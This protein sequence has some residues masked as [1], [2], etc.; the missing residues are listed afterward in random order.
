VVP[1]VA[2]AASRIGQRFKEA[3]GESVADLAGVKEATVAAL[4]AP[5]P[6]KRRSAMGTGL[7]AVIIAALIGLVVYY[8]NDEERRKQFLSTAQSIAEQG[9]EIVR[10]FQGYDEEF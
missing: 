3:G 5:A 8:L 6:S 2:E 9:R 4:T 10:D 7:W 1:Q